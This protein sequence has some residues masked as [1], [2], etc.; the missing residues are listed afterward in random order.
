MSRSSNLRGA[1]LFLRPSV[2]RAL[3][4]DVAAIRKAVVE[5]P[6]LPVKLV[7]RP[8][9]SEDPRLA[10]AN[11]DVAVEVAVVAEPEPIDAPAAP[12]PEHSDPDLDRP[13]VDEPQQTRLPMHPIPHCAG[14]PI[15]T[16]SN[17][18]VETKTNADQSEEFRNR[19]EEGRARPARANPRRRVRPKD[20]GSPSDRRVSGSSGSYDRDGSARS[21][22]PP[23]AEASLRELSKPAPSP[24]TPKSAFELMPSRS[25]AEPRSAP[26]ARPPL[27]LTFEA[28]RARLE[29]AIAHLKRHCI[30]VSVS[31]RDAPVRLYR[32]SGRRESKFAEE[33]IEIA[34]EYGLEL[35]H[36]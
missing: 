16:V 20:S 15:G 30:L 6:L 5:V 3:V 34:Q 21:G 10:K 32:V 1:P 17:K 22:R 25:S 23:A 26:A 19:P 4:G 11:D 31:D 33:V 18:R 13:T 35:T 9:A 28:R 12:M 14:E 2:V 27:P 7:D 29:A 8:R 24:A 36:A